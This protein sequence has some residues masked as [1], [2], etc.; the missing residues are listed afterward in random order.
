MID[1][2][3]IE[4]IWDAL[5]SYRETCIPEGV[6]PHYDV[7]WSDICT[8]MAKIE[9]ELEVWE[10]VSLDSDTMIDAIKSINKTI[11]EGL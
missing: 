9:E 2:N 4:T 5:H 7:I 3:E 11:R 1:R 10:N 8:V 6:T